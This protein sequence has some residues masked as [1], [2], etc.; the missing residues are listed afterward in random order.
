M[1]DAKAIQIMLTKDQWLSRQGGAALE[2]AKP[3]YHEGM[4]IRL[5]A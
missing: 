5:M 2:I 4:E 1:A 3:V